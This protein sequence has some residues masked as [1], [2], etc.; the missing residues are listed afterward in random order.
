[1]PPGQDSGI[2]MMNDA[3]EKVL[4]QTGGKKRKIRYGTRKSRVKRM[5]MKSRVRKN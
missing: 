1:M 3:I 5:R 4:T 2:T